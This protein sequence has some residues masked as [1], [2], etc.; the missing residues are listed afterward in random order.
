MSNTVIG[1]AVIMG[2]IEVVEED[3][4]YKTDLGVLIVFDSVDSIRKAISDGECKFT[5]GDE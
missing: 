3:E 2:R 5:F 4:N 1:R